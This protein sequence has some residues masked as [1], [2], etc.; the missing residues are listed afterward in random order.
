MKI[1][2]YLAELWKSFTKSNK[3]LS[4]YTAVLYDSDV[5]SILLYCESVED[6]REYAISIR[7]RGQVVWK[8]FTSTEYWMM[9]T[10]TYRLKKLSNES[11]ILIDEN[12]IFTNANT[13]YNDSNDTSC[14][15]NITK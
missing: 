15:N 7:K 5:N 14:S 1:L 10:M 11:Y 2:I 12:T 4:H 6:L 13:Y 8:G 9:K 3:V